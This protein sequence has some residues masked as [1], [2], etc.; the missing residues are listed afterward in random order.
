MVFFLNSLIDPK[1]PSLLVELFLPSHSSSC[2]RV[3]VPISTSAPKEGPRGE[4]G[5]QGDL[6]LDEVGGGVDVEGDERVDE[7]VVAHAFEGVELGEGELERGGFLRTP[8]GRRPVVEKVNV[9][10]R[11]ETG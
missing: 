4:K 9:E 7:L 3:P 2:L 11:R 6:P 1:N 8:T 5:R 10:K